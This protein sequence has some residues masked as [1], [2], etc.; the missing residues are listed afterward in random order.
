MTAVRAI[1]RT[2]PIGVS[3]DLLR[4]ALADL[5]D[6]LR[7]YADVVNELTAGVLVDEQQVDHAD[8]PLDDEVT[9]RGCYLAFELVPLELEQNEI[10]GARLDDL[11]GHYAIPPFARS[12]CDPANRSG[13][14]APDARHGSPASSHGNGNGEISR[15]YHPTRVRRPEPG[16]CFAGAV[17][18]TAQGSPARRSPCV[19]VSARSRRDDNRAEGRRRTAE[20]RVANGSL[21][22]RREAHRRAGRRCPPPAQGIGQLRAQ[23]Q[24]PRHRPPLDRRE[25]RYGPTRRT[26]PA[27]VLPRHPRL[28]AQQGRRRCPRPPCATQGR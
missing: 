7:W 2:S 4:D 28:D 1:P 15:G 25:P 21:A 14:D 24:R 12:L 18:V 26:D 22:R 3:S 16:W 27:G 10:D 9:Q 19:R 8:E 13:A 5:V 11:D 6:D 20:A 23:A 17:G